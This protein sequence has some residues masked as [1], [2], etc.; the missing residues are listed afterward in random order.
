MK[1]LI[2]TIAFYY[3]SAAASF[4][5][6]KTI[7]DSKLLHLRARV[8][9]P[10]TGVFLSK[11]PIGILGGLNTYQ[12][13]YSDPV[14][15]RDPKGL[16]TGIDDGGAAIIG[17]L[18]GLGS[19]GVSDLITGELSSWQDYTS[20][21]VGGAA[22]G[23][24]FLY[25]GPVGAAAISG[26]TTNASRQG[27]NLVTGQQNNFSV[28]SLA[29]ETG[30]SAALA[31]AGGKAGEKIL[32]AIASK[33]P[34]QTKGI[35]GEFLTESSARLRGENILNSRF[36]NGQQNITLDGYFTPTGR[37]KYTAV[38]LVSEI[39]GTRFFTEAKFGTSK[40]TTNQKIFQSIEPNFRLDKWSYEWIKDVG[41]SAGSVLGIGL[42]QTTNNIGGV[43]ID[44]AATL[45]GSNLSNIKGASFDPVS[46]QLIFLGDQ[47]PTEVEAINMDYFYTAI[48]AVYGSISSPSVS[49]DPSASALTTWSNFGDGDNVLENDEWGGFVLRYNPVWHDEDTTID[50]KV[51]G[52]SAGI[53]F[54]W[55][56]RF[57]AVVMDGTSGGA[58]QSG[59]RY[60]TKLVFDRWVSAPPIGVSLNQ[61]PFMI[62]SFS[63]WS[64]RLTPDSQNSHFQFNLYNGSSSNFIIDRVSVLPARQHRRFGG[65]VENTQLGWVM[66]EADRVMK[67][68]SVGKDLSLIHI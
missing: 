39:D 34:T 36:T 33:L 16:Y 56:A 32:P 66:Y 24:A 52:Q 48:N 12:Y 13:A 64:F 59:D 60:V 63:G 50:V 35:I 49:L 31:F 2:L 68:L 28:T 57:N 3:G 29:V 6:Q 11:D 44:K 38:D 10:E 61:T 37:T 40:L 55:V 43:L 62:G 17:A 20:S 27:L 46:K 23:V 45:I 67:C 22:G 7:S 54:E 18:I 26:A 4:T 42:G 25:T 15:H 9:D 21:A 41:N 30:T 47:N 53:D 5:G 51:F 14:N 1:Y 8:Y 58:L 65:L 19:Q